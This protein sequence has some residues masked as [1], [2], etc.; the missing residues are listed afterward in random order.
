M[1]TL[2]MRFQRLPKWARIT[3]LLVAELKSIPSAAHVTDVTCLQD[4]DDRH[5]RCIVR[6]SDHST[7]IYSALVDPSS[8]QVIYELVA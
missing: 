6:A 2:R 3:G 8:G 5:F 1:T 4:S 7:A